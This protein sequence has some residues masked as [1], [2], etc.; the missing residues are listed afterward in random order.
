[1][2]FIKMRLSPSVCVVLLHGVDVSRSVKTCTCTDELHYSCVI[3]CS[4]VHTMSIHMTFLTLVILSTCVI[5]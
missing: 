3:I 5:F 2:L 4:C 1:M